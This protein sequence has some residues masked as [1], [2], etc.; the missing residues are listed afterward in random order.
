MKKII[1]FNILA[2]LSYLLLTHAGSAQQEHKLVWADE[3]NGNSLDYSKWGVEENALGGG[4]NELQAY[5]WNKK[6]LRV[7]GGNLVIEAHKDN[8]N[9][10]GTTRPYSSGRIRSKL[11]G[12][13]TY[14]R[15]DVRAKLPIGQGMW[16]AIWMLPTEEKYGG[17]A[18]S[19]EID[20][21]E[22]VGHE[23]STYHGTLHYGGGWP[24]NKHTGKKYKLASGTF[25]DDFHVF[26]ILWE[27]GKIT[28]A[29]DGKP[30]QTQKNWYSEKAPFPAPFDQAFTSCS[31][32][33]WADGGPATRTPKPSFPP[34]C[35][36][37]T[38]GSTKRRS[39]GVGV[40]LR[41]GA[42]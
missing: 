8:P 21:M 27:K 29:I 9:M 18:S 14:C 10:S 13:W 39:K 20:I 15:V 5:L 23:P 42:V 6:N 41:I 25:A 3:F 33:R 31:I 40:T 38:S 34:K 17:W 12:D 2:S 22:L 16:P 36:L 1:T 32:W 26:S 35:W 4:N 7:E 28:W 11:R 37:T 24:R 30:W 19:G